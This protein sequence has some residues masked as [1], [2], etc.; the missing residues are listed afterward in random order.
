MPDVAW[1]AL[2]W[3]GLE[4]AKMVMAGDRGMTAS[5]VAVAVLDG[6]PTHVTYQLGTDA[7]GVVRDV[8]LSTPAGH[9]KLRCDGAGNWEGRPELDGCVDVDI[10]ITPLTNALPIR[11]LALGPDESTTIDVAYVSVPGLAVTRAVQRYTRT[12]TGYRYESG[13]SVPT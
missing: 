7:A 6:S 13:S 9:L 10:A 4:H 12:P 11:R 2:Q 1:A 3:P 5:G 8:N